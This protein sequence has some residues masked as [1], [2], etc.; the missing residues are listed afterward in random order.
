MVNSISFLAFHYFYFF[1]GEGVEFID[2]GV[3]GAVEVFA[4]VFVVCFVSVCF[5]GFELF[6]LLL[7]FGE[8]LSFVIIVKVYY[9][10]PV[11]KRIGVSPVGNKARESGLYFFKSF[12]SISQ[13]LRILFSKPGPIVSFECTGTTVHLPSSC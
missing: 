11:F 2:F 10:Y 8:Y 6:F 1:G 12:N 13:S 4:F 7:G 3:D 5:Y 9:V